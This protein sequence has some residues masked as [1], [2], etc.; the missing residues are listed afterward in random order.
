MPEFS[1]NNKGLYFRKFFFVNVSAG[2]YFLREGKAKNALVF[3]LKMIK[4]T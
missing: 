4:S 3:E 2:T 1:A